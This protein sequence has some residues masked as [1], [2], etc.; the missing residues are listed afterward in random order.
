M[1]YVIRTITLT[2]E[3]HFGGRIPSRALGKVLETISD[4]VLRS[5]SMALRGRSATNGL[6][7]ALLEA[8]SDIRFV[9][10][11]GADESTLVF[12][13]PTLGES[14]ID[15]YDPLQNPRSLPDP[16]QTSIDLLANVISEVA[17]KNFDSDHYDKNLLKCLMRFRFALK[18]T[19]R[20][21]RFDSNNPS[22]SPP[23]IDMHWIEIAREIHSATPPPRRVRIVGTLDML[24]VSTQG[25][26]LRLDDGEA[27][28]GVLRT[29]SIV[30]VAEILNRRVMIVGRAIYRASGRVLRIDADS[31]AV[32]DS[33][34]SIWTKIP[35]PVALRSEIRRRAL[36][37]RS[38]NGA[39]TLIGCWPGEET[40]E[41]IDKALKEIG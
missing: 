11:Y 5:I 8:A 7:P 12:E 3:R 41:E 6:R 23:A 27:V 33:T 19:F 34:E 17:A 37:K 28:R 31:I 10:H 15:L 20:E 38:R 21:I 24:R 26:E 9:E 35:S 25:F 36:E 2:S 29:G 22:T 13:I 30:D 4:S 32:T 40:D 16:D 1:K 39:A 18:G 14:L